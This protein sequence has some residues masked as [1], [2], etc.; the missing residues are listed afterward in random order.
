MAVTLVTVLESRPLK[1]LTR[2]PVDIRDRC[3]IVQ[4]SCLLPP[5]SHLPRLE[6]TPMGYTV[7]LKTSAAPSSLS[8]SCLLRQ[9]TS[10]G[11]R[12]SW[13]SRFSSVMS[14]R[15]K[16]IHRQLQPPDLAKGQSWREPLRVP[17]F[18]L[19]LAVCL[20]L[21]L[22]LE[23]G[24]PSPLIDRVMTSKYGTP[25]C[26]S[27]GAVVTCIA[28]QSRLGI[29]ALHVARAVCCAHASTFAHPSSQSRSQVSFQST[30]FHSNS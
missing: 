25:T 7:A 6:Y 27:T 11:S 22:D 12:T 23:L 21:T 19:H 15:P 30:S 16:E 26:L 1:S 2:I 4:A 8:T 17:F 10:Q 29:A 13:V 5:P 28:A 24:S 3:C 18:C 20:D 14:S 9:S